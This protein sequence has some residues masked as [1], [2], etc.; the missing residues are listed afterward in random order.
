ML[1]QDKTSSPERDPSGLREEGRQTG[2]SKGAGPEALTRKRKLLFFPLISVN[3]VRKETFTAGASFP[4]TR[5][6]L[7]NVVGSDYFGPVYSPAK[8]FSMFSIFTL[9]LTNGV[10]FTCRHHL[11]LK[12]KKPNVASTICTFE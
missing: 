8:R 11:Q 9:G 1:T 2:Q 10:R 4:N 12:K 6:V 7:Q 3:A 5:R